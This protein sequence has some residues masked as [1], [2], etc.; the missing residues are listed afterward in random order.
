MQQA[1]LTF[2][3]AGT[4]SAQKIFDTVTYSDGKLTGKKH[5]ISGLSLCE[6][7]VI[8]VKHGQSHAVVLFDPKEAMVETVTTMGMEDTLTVHATFD[9]T[10]AVFLYGRLDPL[11][12]PVDSH[13]HLSFLTIQLG[14]MESLLNDIDAYTGVK[15]D[16]EKKKLRTDVEIMSLLWNQEVA[17]INESYHEQHTLWDRRAV[18]YAFGKKAL[19]NITNFVSEVT[20]SGLFEPRMP[21]H[22]RYKDALIYS[23]HMRN[24]PA[25]VDFLFERRVS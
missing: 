22:Q 23:T 10:P 3:G 5:W 9:Q 16:Y 13:L 18:I 24:V 14:L 2:D 11:C 1:N 19:T 6:W 4:W 17:V 15:F 12:F 8:S 7:A 25:A 21:E 20:G